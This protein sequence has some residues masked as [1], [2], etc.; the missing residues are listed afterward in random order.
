MQR[1]IE[2]RGNQ[3]KPNCEHKLKKIV[4]NEIFRRQSK[5]CKIFQSLSSTL[6]DG[7]KSEI[8]TGYRCSYFNGE[9]G[10]LWKLHKKCSKRKFSIS[11]SWMLRI[12]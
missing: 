12:K 6:L 1:N 2:I 4:P 8:F 9:F 11:R 7:E 10:S 5:D 3:V